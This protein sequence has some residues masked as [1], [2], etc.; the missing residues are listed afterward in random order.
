MIQLNIG[1][2]LITLLRTSHNTPYHARPIDPLYRSLLTNYVVAKT[3]ERGTSSP[4][5][6]NGMKRWSSGSTSPR[7]TRCRKI[8]Y[9]TAGIH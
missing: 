8:D 1:E 6:I 7:I 4:S 2:A 3:P 5:R 9:R